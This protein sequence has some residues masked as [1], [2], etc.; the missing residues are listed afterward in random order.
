MRYILYYTQNEMACMSFTVPLINYL[1]KD[2][3]QGSNPQH[4]IVIPVFQA[5]H[6]GN[7]LSVQILVDFARCHRAAFVCSSSELIFKRDIV[8]FSMKIIL[9][10]KIKSINVL[11]FIFQVQ[12]CYSRKALAC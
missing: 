4:G 10:I 2:S 5:M 1:K 3:L 11:E 7:K 9:L 6:K 8:F 12:I